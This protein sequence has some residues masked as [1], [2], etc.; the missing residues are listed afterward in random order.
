MYSIQTTLK[1]I[2]FDSSYC[3]DRNQ[4]FYQP[5]PDYSQRRQN[6]QNFFVGY[7]TYIRYIFRKN[8]MKS[9]VQA[10]FFHVR[11]SRCRGK[12]QSDRLEV[13]SSLSFD[14]GLMTKILKIALHSLYTKEQRFAGV[15]QQSVRYIKYLKLGRVFLY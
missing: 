1:E 7:T 11:I 4:T 5:V 10:K 9:L 3:G 8:R 2:F 15:H 6:F 14:N 13:A 12:L